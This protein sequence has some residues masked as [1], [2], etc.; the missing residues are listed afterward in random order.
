MI[1]WILI[2]VVAYLALGLLTAIRFLVNRGR[3]MLGFWEKSITEKNFSED[4]ELFAFCV[5]FLWPPVWLFIGAVKLITAIER[6]IVVPIVN[7]KE[8]KEIKEFMDTAST[9]DLV[10]TATEYTK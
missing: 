3:S 4:D 9:E 1:T 10:K 5:I 7:K 6:Y 2:G 8:K